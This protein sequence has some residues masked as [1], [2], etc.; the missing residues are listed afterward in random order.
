[1]DLVVVVEPGSNVTYQ[2]YQRD[3]G[4]YF[5]QSR[6]IECVKE[7]KVKLTKEDLADIAVRWNLDIDTAW[8]KY[9]KPVTGVGY[10]L[11]S[12]PFVETL[13][14]RGL[15]ELIKASK[16][17]SE[18]GALVISVTKP[19]MP[20]DT[21]HFVKNKEIAL[22]YIKLE[23]SSF[24]RAFQEHL[25]REE[26]LALNKAWNNLDEL[27]S[28]WSQVKSPLKPLFVISKPRSENVPVEPLPT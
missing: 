21:V 12:L 6:M 14:S 20:I 11:L 22:D 10:T 26:K 16:Q 5:I 3:S 15:N 27:L 1:M 4:T 7:G 9:F 23:I 2:L 8:N 17:E 28:A 24:Q 18:D 19:L 13:G 25:S